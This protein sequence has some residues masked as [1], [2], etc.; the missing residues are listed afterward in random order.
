MI[1][2]DWLLTIALLAPAMLPAGLIAQGTPPGPAVVWQ[3]RGAR[4]LEKESAA[5]PQDRVGLAPDKTYTLAELIDFAETVLFKQVIR[6]KRSAIPWIWIAQGAHWRPARISSIVSN[7]SIQTIWRPMKNRK[8]WLDWALRGAANGRKHLL[9]E[10]R[11]V[12]RRA[13]VVAGGS[14]TAVGAGPGNVHG[15]RR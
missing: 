8:I 13:Q 12:L 7:G 15:Q 2:K 14:G 10:L 4:A 3:P 5:K 6:K 9:Y 1:T 11:G